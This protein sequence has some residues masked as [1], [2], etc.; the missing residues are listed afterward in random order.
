MAS[1]DWSSTNIYYDIQRSNGIL[2]I[3][4]YE[5]I[6]NSFSNVIGSEIQEVYGRQF[7]GEHEN[8]LDILNNAESKILSY[9]Q[10]RN[11]LRPI[12]PIGS[13]QYYFDNKT[14]FSELNL[15]EYE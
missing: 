8:V 5:E 2:T 9:Y 3:A 13:S 14:K 12:V 1:E 7:I 11:Y 15:Y 4:Y 6:D 10:V